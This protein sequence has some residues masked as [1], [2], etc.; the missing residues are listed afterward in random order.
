M[1]CI[2]KGY[3]SESKAYRLY[4][5]INK[6]IIISKNVIFFENQSLDGSVDESSRTSS[7]VP[8]IEKEEDDIS[9]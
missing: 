4:G 3:S 7:R 8:T 2:F 9:N 6:K 1:K 5:P